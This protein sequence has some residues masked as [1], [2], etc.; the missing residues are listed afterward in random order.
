DPWVFC[1]GCMNH[2][3]RHQR[4]RAR[5]FKGR[6]SGAGRYQNRKLRPAKWGPTVNLR[7]ENSPARMAAMGHKRTFRSA[8]AMSALP[9]N[10]T[11]GSVGNMGPIV[12]I[13]R[14]LY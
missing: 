8:I 10:Q 5:P 9:P 1:L 3:C 12:K 4:E 7:C 13:G 14:L 2:I 11:L 6:Y